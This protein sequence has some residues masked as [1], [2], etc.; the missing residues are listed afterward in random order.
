MV[1]RLCPTLKKY[2]SLICKVIFFPAKFFLCIL[3]KGILARKK[4]LFKEGYWLR[5]ETPQMKP[6]PPTQNSQEKTIKI[7]DRKPQ[8]IQQC[9]LIFQQ[10]TLLLPTRMRIVPFAR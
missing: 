1:R 8:A 3:E 9:K 2:T 6:Y 10:R 5:N 4:L 7:T